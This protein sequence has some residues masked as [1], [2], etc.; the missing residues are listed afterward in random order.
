MPQRH[1]DLEKVLL[2]IVRV[3]LCLIPFLPFYV[4]SSMLFPF[5]TGKNF[6]FR[7]IIEFIFIAWV[8]LI[9]ISPAYRPRLTTL[10]KAVTIFVGI[11][12]LADLLG[13]N[14]YRS[15]FSNYERME[16]FM[17]I[18][19][20][21]LYFLMLVSVFRKKRDW[22]VFF[23]IVLFAGLAVSY[24]ALLQRLGLR[25]SIQGGFRVDSTI[26]NPAYL[27]AYLLFHV[28]LLFI[29][30]QQFWKKIWLRTIYG[31]LLI[32]QLAIIYFTA[33]R[34][35]TLALLV[36]FVALTAVL[37]FFWKK[38]F[39]SEALYGRKI[40]ISVLTILIVSSAILWQLRNL[41][42]IQS[43]PGLGRLTSYSLSERTIQSRFT[44][45]GMAFKGA[46]E[47]PI[48]G[49]GQE[50]FYLVFQKYFDPKLYASEPWFDRSHNVFFDWLIHTG[51]L[52][53]AGYLSIFGIVFWW[54]WLAFKKRT[55][56]PWQTLMLGGLFVSYFLQ[57]LFVFDNLN[58]Y[59]L[60]FAFLA[61]MQFIAKDLKSE[62]V[63][64]LPAHSN[65]RS[66]QAYAVMSGLLVLLLIV[67]YFIH[68]KPIKEAKAL[69][70]AM[71][72]VNTTQSISDWIASYKK[73]L[74]YGTFGGD[75]VRQQVANTARSVIDHPKFTPEEKKQF[76]EFALE[77][78]REDV[79]NPAKDVKHV[80]FF[81]AIL[82][83]A[84]R[85]NPPYAVEAE[86]VL[87]EAI[88][89]SPKKQVIYFELAQLYL[90]TGHLDRAAEVMRT[91]WHLDLSFKEAAG[92]LWL[93]GI[94]A[95]KPEIIAEVKA[96][97][98]LD[99][100]GEEV[101][102]RLASA[103][104]QVQDYSS[105]LPV[106]ERLVKIAPKNPKYLAVYAA[107]LANFNRNKEA[108]IYAEQAAALDPAF[109][110]EAKEFLKMLKQGK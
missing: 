47:R 83:K 93:T 18:F 98:D 109:A 7:I 10:F 69:I 53:L 43:S 102:S 61:Y 49:W 9:L 64:V 46:L 42:S 60:F 107:L 65:V 57:N 19:H 25:V 101:L 86:K 45:W 76:I 95:K 85:L 72:T 54:L 105:A 30:L 67:G 75:E 24:I 26:G 74:S 73:A 22:L 96:V 4:E 32:F 103:Y 91:A 55:V 28:W 99:S 39:G 21:Y 88:R 33:T 5:I 20:L 2:W 29:L 6:A 44:I 36:S 104:Q 31:L 11:V 66:E 81:G 16:G 52:G 37:A 41:Q 40:A 34:G 13:P 58:T 94:F 63:A 15:F 35:V 1:D 38:F 51:F 87:Q 92:N 110:V 23:N 56:A 78:L 84:M 3:G 90:S 62:E 8:G 59:I 108:K 17:M 82:E 14:P 97:Y 70:Q 106:Y 68:I 71:K 77:E 100:F 12:F 27:A 48:L 80:L 89:L 79:E 50:N